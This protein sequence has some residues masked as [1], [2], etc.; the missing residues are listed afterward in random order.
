[1]L[2]PNAEEWFCTPENVA[3]AWELAIRHRLRVREHGES[4]LFA[5]NGTALERTE[6][7]RKDKDNERE[8][9]GRT[10]RDGAR[11]KRVILDDALDQMLATV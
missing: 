5:Q 10:L 4:A 3:G 7:A 8:A 11:R 2:G 6:Y 9:P 1:M